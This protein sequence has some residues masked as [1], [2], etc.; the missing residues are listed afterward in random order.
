MLGLLGF[1]VVMWTIVL[2]ACGFLIIFVAPLDSLL[3]I[4]DRIV[5]SLVQALIAILL[6]VGL[7]KI[8]DR[9]KKLYTLRK[10]RI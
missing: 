3:A 1:L 9:I 8:L 2:S 5:T 7:V 6:V 4:H 10:L